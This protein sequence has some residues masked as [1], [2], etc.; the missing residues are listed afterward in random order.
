VRSV[1]V[2]DILPETSYTQTFRL[3]ASL[4]YRAGQA[5]SLLIPGDPKKR[6]Y[7][8]S[9]SPTEKG[10]LDITF[11][12]EREKVLYGSLFGLNKGSAVDI[13][14]PMGSF[15]LPEPI[16]G[17]YYFLAG[18]SGVA[19]FRSMIKFILDTRPETVMWLFNSARTPDDL[20]FREQFLEWSKNPDFHYVPTFTRAADFG[21]AGE[22]GRIGEELLKKHLPTMEGTFFI[23]GPKEFVADMERILVR[24]QVPPVR[25]RRENW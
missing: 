18:G 13:H 20:I 5:I 1:K 22:T 8:I 21:M 3:G 6:Y 9:S 25:I 2:L 24:M 14:G 16:A 19:P 15:I 7:S 11:K 4:D 23:C 10:Y 12:A 17:P